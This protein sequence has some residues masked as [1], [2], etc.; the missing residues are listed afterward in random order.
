MGL[1]S[2][3]MKKPLVET[4]RLARFGAFVK[5]EKDKKSPGMP[6]AYLKN[7]GF[8]DSYG[9]LGYGTGMHRH[10][11]IFQES[12]N[13]NAVLYDNRKEA[14]AYAKKLEKLLRDNGYPSSRA[15]AEQVAVCKSEGHPFSGW[16][17]PTVTFE[18]ADRFIIQMRVK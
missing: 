2:E 8:G 1:L 17:L 16:I 7:E 9:K 14:E 5:A 12:D 15:R 4:E 10:M 13:P 11:W 6:Q 3:D 18:S